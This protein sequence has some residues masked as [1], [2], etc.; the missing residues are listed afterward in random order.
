LIQLRGPFGIKVGSA[1]VTKTEFL[2]YNSLEN[3]LIT[4]LSSPDNL[5]RIL[6]V[7]LSFDDLLCLFAGGT[8]LES[9]S[10]APD[11]TQIEDDQFVFE[12]FDG[13]SSR[14]YWVD[15]TSLIIQKV[16]F[17]DH[18]RTV[19]LEQTFRKFEDTDGLSMPYA[20]SI[21]QPRVHQRLSII[22][23]EIR[24]NTEKLHFTFIIPPNAERI[25]W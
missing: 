18:N 9:D 4:G 2:F 16:Q 5:N 7:Q 14:K 23:S 22:Y 17:F 12:F 3:K 10:H 15:P 21:D 13:L 8:F 11:D 19:A 20:I 24:L 1:L 25:H 6:H